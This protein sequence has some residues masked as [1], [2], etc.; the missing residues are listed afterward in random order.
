[1]SKVYIL[2]EEADLSLLGR[3]RVSKYNRA[4]EWI[5]FQNYPLTVSSSWRKC[6]KW[7]FFKDSITNV[8]FLTVLGMITHKVIQGGWMNV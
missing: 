2:G 4:V 1:M 5:V 7:K 3:S 6:T 8:G